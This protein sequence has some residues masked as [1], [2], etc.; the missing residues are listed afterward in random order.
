MTFFLQ[1]I[2]L[3]IPSENTLSAAG[4]HREEKTGNFRAIE[5]QWERFI[6]IYCETPF[7]GFNACFS[8]ILLNNQNTFLFLTFFISNVNVLRPL[9]G[10]N[11]WSTLRSC[12]SLVPLYICIISIFWWALWS[13]Y[14]KGISVTRVADPGRVHRDPDP[15]PEKKPGSDSRG[16]I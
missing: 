4:F 13:R 1:D 7:C 10:G 12:L 5:A 6:F 2:A 3:N 16:T 9:F 15:A 14:R 8:M 11:C